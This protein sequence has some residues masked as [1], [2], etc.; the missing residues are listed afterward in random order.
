VAQQLPPRPVPD[1]LED[2]QVL[3]DAA[4]GKALDLRGDKTGIAPRPA[5]TEP[6]KKDQ[7]GAPGWRG[8]R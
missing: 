2:H 4:D 1:R 8:T 6:A 3:L 5:M 7:A